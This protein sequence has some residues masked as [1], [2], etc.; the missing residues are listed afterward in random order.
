[1]G[2]F[3]QSFFIT[4][5]FSDVR[6]ITPT[7]N[8]FRVIV[9]QLFAASLLALLALALSAIT[10][11]ATLPPA[12]GPADHVIS[13]QL[14]PVIAVGLASVN[15]RPEIAAS[16]IFA[17]R[18]GLDMS[19]VD[20]D[21]AAAQVVSL[22][23]LGHRLN[24]QLVDQVGNDEAVAAIVHASVSHVVQAALPVPARRS[25]MSVLG[26]YLDHGKDFRED[27]SV[28]GQTGWLCGHNLG[29]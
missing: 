17:V 26:A 9:R 27:F 23:S 7:L 15:A 3:L 28:N 16:Q 10:A 14:V 24:E 12:V 29:V 25:V 18:D 2:S 13:T 11:C 20:A 19:R 8:P 22:Q 4:P 6:Q 5:A 1:M 21:R